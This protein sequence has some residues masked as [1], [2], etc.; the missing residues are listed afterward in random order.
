M[1]AGVAGLSSISAKLAVLGPIGWAAASYQYGNKSVHWYW[2]SAIPAML[3]LALVM[4]QYYPIS[5]THS[6]PGYLKPAM[7]N[8]GAR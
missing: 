6:V 3:F 8:P 2:I 7:V 4:M 5:K 1:T